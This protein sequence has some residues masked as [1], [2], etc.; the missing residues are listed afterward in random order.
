MIGGLVDTIRGA[1]YNWCDTCEVLAPH[2]ATTDETA[3]MTN[4]TS[5]NRSMLIRTLRWDAC[6]QDSEMSSFLGAAPNNHGNMLS[7][8]TACPPLSHP[9]DTGTTCVACPPGQVPRGTV[10]ASDG[11]ACQKCIS[12]IAG[13][14][15][16][17]HDCGANQI[18]VGN[19]CVD[20]PKGQGADKA[21]NTCKQC[22]ID[23]TAV[24]PCQTSPGCGGNQAILIK[25]A[26]TPDDICPNEFWLELTGWSTC[27][28]GEVFVHLELP[29]SDGTACTNA[30]GH[31][32]A[33]YPGNPGV[34][35]GETPTLNFEYKTAFCTADNK[36]C[37]PD[38]CY[39]AAEG[40]LVNTGA[41]SDTKF[42]IEADASLNGSPVA[43]VVRLMTPACNIN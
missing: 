5:L 37:L 17:C 13:Q 43:G 21:T 39:L 18:T 28:I 40:A 4:P 15:N 11:T 30:L 25:W 6:T 32:A 36:Y 31:Y 26:G 23:A 35:A 20:C 1:G 14:D 27:Y 22:P 3:R 12:G 19:T 8:C 38:G 16:E 34:L 33:Y 10:G 9:E 7:N 41:T 2:Y 42:W 29:N 24:V